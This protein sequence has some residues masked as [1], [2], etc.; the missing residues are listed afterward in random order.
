MCSNNSEIYTGGKETCR[1]SL[2]MLQD[3]AIGQQNDFYVHTNLHL[4]QDVDSIIEYLGDHTVESNKCDN[5]ISF[6]FL[7]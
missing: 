5:D 6:C 7:H 4:S 3:C 1:Q 2:Q